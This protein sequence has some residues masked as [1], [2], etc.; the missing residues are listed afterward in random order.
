MVIIDAVT[1]LIPGVLKK[2]QATKNESFSRLDNQTI[3]EY[4]QYTRPE[5]FLNLKVPGVLLSGDHEKISVW[6]K[7]KSQ[8]L[9][10]KY[11]PDLLEK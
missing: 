5:V 9:T 2:P 7:R 1:R 10:K 4:P 6:Q 8:K 3:L 11:R